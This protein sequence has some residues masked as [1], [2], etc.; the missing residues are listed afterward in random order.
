MN[1]LGIKE[2]KT[3]H[4]YFFQL[5]FTVNKKRAQYR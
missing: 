5:S 2:T 3:A 1:T 4:D